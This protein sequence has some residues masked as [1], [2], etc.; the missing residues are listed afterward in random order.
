MRSHA[1]QEIEDSKVEAG[2]RPEV[3]KRSDVSWERPKASTKR[4]DAA[5]TLSAG[6]DSRVEG[7]KAEAGPQRNE[8]AGTGWGWQAAP[9]QRRDTEHRFREQEGLQEESSD[10]DAVSQI[11]MDLVKMLARLGEE[12]VG[13][14]STG[15]LQAEGSA[16]ISPLSRPSSLPLRP[17]ILPL[18]RD[19]AGLPST[20]RQLA[21]KD[22]PART[23]ADNAGS[24]V[25]GSIGEAVG[26]YVQAYSAGNKP[27]RNPSAQ[28]AVTPPPRPSWKDPQQPRTRALTTRLNPTP[29]AVDQPDLGAGPEPGGV[30]GGMP[31][32]E[33]V[34]FLSKMLEDVTESLNAEISRAAD[35]SAAVKRSEGSSSGRDPALNNTRVAKQPQRQKRR[36]E[37]AQTEH[38][39]SRG[40]DRNPQSADVGVSRKSPPEQVTR[41]RGQ[42]PEAGPGRAASSTRGAGR[43]LADK[44]EMGTPTQ[45]LRALGLD[46][47]LPQDA[48]SRSERGDARLSGVNGVSQAD[49]AGAGKE[50]QSPLALALASEQ[51][52]WLH[53]VPDRPQG[54]SPGEARIGEP[55]ERNEGTG[56]GLAPKHRAGEQNLPLSTIELE[57][58]EDVVAIRRIFQREPLHEENASERKQEAGSRHLYGKDRD[59]K[60][61]N[62]KGHDG[63]ARPARLRTD[64]RSSRKLLSQQDLRSIGTAPHAQGTKDPVA[65][66]ASRADSFVERWQELATMRQ[67]LSGSSNATARGIVEQDMLRLAQALEHDPQLKTMLRSRAHE[68]GLEQFQWAD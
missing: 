48:V 14:E 7:K 41:I 25:T 51:R 58:E 54:V 45:R 37:G 52:E 9:P 62:G 67:A 6:P 1:A 13:S 44:P 36:E 39:G 10:D 65:D 49:P 59:G 50:A 61:H 21:E 55:V 34:L 53:S 60:G 4:R 19:S 24:T 43:P 5:Q 12:A 35:T 66:L 33:R 40:H 8:T 29:E 30:V 64:Q 47:G 16:G 68:L 26:R 63:P 23:F 22:A 3:P 42:S 32:E 2:F 28:G 15:T 31:A 27:G 38:P 17:E 56:I 18:T 20:S 11:S 46:L 57:D